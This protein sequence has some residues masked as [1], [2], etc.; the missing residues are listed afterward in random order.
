MYVSKIIGKSRASP[1]ILLGMTPYQHEHTPSGGLQSRLAHYDARRERLKSLGFPATYD[2]IA[3]RMGTTKSAIARIFSGERKRVALED[4]IQLARVLDQMEAEARRALGDDALDREQIAEEPGRPDLPVS[5][6]GFLSAGASP[7]LPVYGPVLSGVNARLDHAGVVDWV[8]LDDMIGFTA[9]GRAPFLLEVTG[10][11]MEP[12]YM[13]GERVLV[14]RNRPPRQGE[15][16]VF[17]FADGHAELKIYR[18]RRGNQ[19]WFDQW[20][21]DAPDYDPA[22][23]TVNAADVR[24]LHAVLRF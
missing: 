14:A 9:P 23:N 1:A 24:A 19:I 18:G 10:E 8:S 21:H 20:N 6:P 12:R 2:D 7:R 13:H 15:D 11:S 3:T 5:A 17:E 16:A 22:A 4:E